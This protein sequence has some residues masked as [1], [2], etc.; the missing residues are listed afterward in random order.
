M[1]YL[2]KL[3]LT[4]NADCIAQKFGSGQQKMELIAFTLF[5]HIRMLYFSSYFRI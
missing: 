1:Y 4:Q 5:L 3:P 2:H